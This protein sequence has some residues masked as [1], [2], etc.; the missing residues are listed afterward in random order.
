VDIAKAVITVLTETNLKRVGGEKVFVLGSVI[1]ES[2]S[3]SV[4]CVYRVPQ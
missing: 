3:K 2:D 1:Y 4:L